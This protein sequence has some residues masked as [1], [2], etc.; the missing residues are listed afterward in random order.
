M[1]LALLALLFFGGH[2][3]HSFV[4][5]MIF[6]V[7]LVGTYTSVFIAAPI[8]IYLGVGV[9]RGAADEAPEPSLHRRPRA[10]LRR[11]RPRA[12]DGLE[13]DRRRYA[14]SALSRGDRS[15]M[16]RAVSRF[17]G[18]SHRGSLLCLPNGIWA[19]PV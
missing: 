10:A 12:R 7:V 16:A 5:T 9:T 6:G 8:L 19:W 18:M 2:A 14:A 13:L 1:T 3:I 11:A 4:A 17:A 15:G